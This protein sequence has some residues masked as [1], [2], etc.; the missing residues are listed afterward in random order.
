MLFGQPLPVQSETPSAQGTWHSSL[1]DE[2]AHLTHAGQYLA[3]CLAV[4]DQVQ[5]QVHCACPREHRMLTGCPHTSICEHANAAAHHC[6]RLQHTDIREW[7]EHHLRLGVG[8]FYVY[9]NSTIP[10]LAMFQDLVRPVQGAAALS[11][12]VMSHGCL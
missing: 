11:C 6:T 9:D 4:K 7:L 8:K 10:M 2:M 1:Q 5:L 3:L 12:L